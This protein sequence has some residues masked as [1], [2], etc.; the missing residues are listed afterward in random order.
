MVMRENVPILDEA[1]NELPAFASLYAEHFDFVWRSLRHLGIPISTMDDAAQDVWLIVHR[2]LAGFQARSSVT[3]WLFGIVMNVARG[4][5][6]H[7][8]ERQPPE[9]LP[10]ELV[11][12]GPDPE[13]VL[14]GNQAWR[15][16]QGFLDGLP[17]QSRAIFVSA[18]L[19]NFT[20]AETAEVVGVDVVT[21]YKKIRALRR[22][23]QRRLSSGEEDRS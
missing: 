5:R 12:H 17:E 16:V 10:E 19:E 7:K 8:S 2:R 11:S 15:L 3:T 1:Q 23:F 9:P 14:S 22:A 18:L 4:R 13:G 6:R 21:V 20:P